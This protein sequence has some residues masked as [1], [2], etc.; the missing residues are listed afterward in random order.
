MQQLAG[1]MCLVALA[2]WHNTQCAAGPMLF[3]APGY[4]SAVS[5]DMFCVLSTYHAYRLMS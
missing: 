3:G 2:G 4:K 1:K 5:L